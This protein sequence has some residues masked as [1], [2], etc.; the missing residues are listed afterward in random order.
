MKCKKLLHWF[1]SKE[2]SLI[3]CGVWSVLFSSSS[4]FL[5]DWMQTKW[6]E[7][8]QPSSTMRWCRRGWCWLHSSRSSKE[9]SDSEITI[10]EIPSCSWLL[11]SWQG[12]SWLRQ[13]TENEKR[14]W[15]KA[16]PWGK[17][18]FTEDE[19]AMEIPEGSSLHRP[20]YGVSSVSVCN[21]LMCNYQDS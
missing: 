10:W 18:R 21:S 5:S 8:K 13:Q 1:F 15:P 17:P 11:K 2:I 16:E 19:L 20:Y 14:R 12:T 7:L 4:F 6:L 9:T 3:G